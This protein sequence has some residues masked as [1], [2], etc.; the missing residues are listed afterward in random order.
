MAFQFSAY[1]DNKWFL[2]FII[3]FASLLSFIN[4]GALPLQYWDESRYGYIA[5]EMLRRNDFINYFYVNGYDYAI[6]KPP[7]GIW[8]IAVSYKIFGFNEFALR[9][10]SA[11]AV[12]LF[13]IVFYKW[14][15]QYSNHLS[16]FF[17]CLILMVCK[18]II[19]DHVGR[20]G[21]L[22]ALLLL[23]LT[24]AIYIFSK[25]VDFN[26]RSS[27]FFVFFFLGLGFY[28][29]GA[30]MALVLPPMFVYLLLRRKFISALKNNY[31]WL[32]ILT[33]FLLVASWYFMVDRYGI[34]SNDGFHKGNTVFERM[35]MADGLQRFS[36]D[37][38]DGAATT[39]KD[40]LFYI[41][42]LDSR[43]NLW[44]YLFYCCCV[45]F[46]A[47]LCV[48]KVR[49]NFWQ[50]FPASAKAGIT[51]AALIVACELMV[52]SFSSTK[53]LWYLAPALPFI[54]FFSWQIIS[55]YFSKYR[56]FRTVIVFLLCFTF[57]RNVYELNH[58]HS[59]AG[60]FLRA[61]QHVIKA[62]K[63]VL[64]YNSEAEPDLILYFRWYA[65]RHQTIKAAK[66][67]FGDLQQTVIFG[68]YDDQIQSFLAQ[69]KKA[70]FR[71]EADYFI[72]YP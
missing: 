59:N 29:K 19:G 56:A 7:L 72:L 51:F 41:Q 68:R 30:A 26:S 39:S 63:E 11:L 27:I 33:F 69:N 5:C 47:L 3:I 58:A 34:R 50:N 16:A 40:F 46:V 70:N 65:P 44:N 67:P 6:S 4:L 12:V 2:L 61:H 35:F 31:T 17:T 62:S 66:L 1:R 36:E 14:V 25:F 10:P 57:V 13:F 24:C 32:G 49:H 15:V 8:A 71:R 60:T 18:G 21:D 45:F 38:Y 22:D 52:L 53:Y 20:T 9:F 64:W 43:F 54:A 28:T 37:K 55:P 48:K 23:F 42:A